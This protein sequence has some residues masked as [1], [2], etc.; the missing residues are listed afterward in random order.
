MSP[1]KKSRPLLQTHVP[2][3]GHTDVL[4]SLLKPPEVPE[5]AAQTARC[6]GFT[7]GSEAEALVRTLDDVILSYVAALFDVLKSLR[8]VCGVDAGVSGGPTTSHD[9]E[10]EED[11]STV[12]ARAS[13]PA[14]KLFP[15]VF[16]H[17]SP[18][19]VKWRLTNPHPYWL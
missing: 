19:L 13:L 7:G 10:G 4:H 11:W 5:T 16:L 17:K 9:D 18:A 6:L 8:T 14:Y 1:G 2:I 15:L 12:Q 3:S